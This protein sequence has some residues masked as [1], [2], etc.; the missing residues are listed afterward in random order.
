MV[1]GGGKAVMGGY[2]GV[3]VKIPILVPPVLLWWWRMMMMMMWCSEDLQWWHA[4][5]RVD[6][7]GLTVVWCL[8]VD[9]WS[10]EDLQWWCTSFTSWWGGGGVITSYVSLMGHGVGPLSFPFG[11]SSSAT[12]VNFTQQQLGQLLGPD[13]KHSASLLGGAAI[14]KL[15]FEAQPNG[16]SQK[17]GG[18]VPWL[19]CKRWCLGE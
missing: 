13:L 2:L 19:T 1:K 4:S 6:D 11:G 3:V 17:L 18:S 8:L 14:E 15:A 10:D 7:G 12:E 9:E 5:L 16:C